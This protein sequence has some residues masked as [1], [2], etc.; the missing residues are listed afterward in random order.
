M[1]FIFFDKKFCP[2]RR[3]RIRWGVPVITFVLIGSFFIAY[4]S[5]HHPIN[6]NSNGVPQKEPSGYAYPRPRHEIQGFKYEGIVQG[7]KNMMITADSFTIQKKKIGFLR[8]GLLQEAVLINAKI[9]LYGI[10]L[11]ETGNGGKSTMDGSFDRVFSSDELMF[12]PERVASV[13]LMG[14]AFYLHGD[15]NRVTGFS[16]QKG[17]IR[18]KDKKILFTKQARAFFDD[19][20][21][22]AGRISVTLDKPFIVASQG[23]SYRSGE[24]LW[25]GQ[26]LTTDLLLNRAKQGELKALNDR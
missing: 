1:A 25:S 8:F 6:F 13:R 17:E 11:S 7:R 2:S 12:T 16:S 4:V 26:R 5:F 23:V 24:T 20:Q 22:N 9:H 19:R 18:F 3:I 15:A 14:V 10:D 21:I